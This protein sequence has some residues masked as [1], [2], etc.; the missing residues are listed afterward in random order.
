[1]QQVTAMR[2]PCTSTKSSPHVPQLEKAGE[3]QW[4]PSTAENEYIQENEFLNSFRSHI[5]KSRL[6]YF[7]ENEYAEFSV[8]SCHCV[9][10]ILP[11]PVGPRLYGNWS[12]VIL[13]SPSLPISFFFFFFKSWSHFYNSS[14][15]ILTIFSGIYSYEFEVISKCTN[16]THISCKCT[17]PWQEKYLLTY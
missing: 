7:S 4:R 2:G 12:P 14:V 15:H 3:Q 9:L 11:T 10:G 5:C 6:K 1:M 13:V 16:I 8:H 17:K